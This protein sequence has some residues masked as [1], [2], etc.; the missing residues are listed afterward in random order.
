MTQNDAD[1]SQSI[2]QCAE[3][4]AKGVYIVTKSVGY[5]GTD[6]IGVY[7]TAALAEQAVRTAVENS[8]YAEYDDGEPREFVDD[9]DDHIL[10][11]TVFDATYS[12]ERHSVLSEVDQ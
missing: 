1:T 4:L 2:E 10:S 12:A 11:M 8:K 6:I 7:P 3:Q 5:G 9:D